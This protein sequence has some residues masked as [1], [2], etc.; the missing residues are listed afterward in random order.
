MVHYEK[1][2]R[3]IRR[4]FNPTVKFLT[5]RLGLSLHVAQVLAVRGRKSGQWRTVPVYPLRFNGQQYLVAPRGETEWVRNLRARCTGELSQASKVKS[6]LASEVNEEAKPSLLH[7]Y[8][9]RWAAEA[10]REFGV[11]GKNAP[12]RNCDRSGQSTPSF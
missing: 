12:R 2:G 9:Q 6:F 4:V 10:A 3:I 7:A 5:G 1:S 11:S 8:L